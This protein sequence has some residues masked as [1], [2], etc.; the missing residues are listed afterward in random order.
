MA[1]KIGS[2]T[3]VHD[4]GHTGIDIEGHTATIGA[5]NALSGD[6]SGHVLNFNNTSQIIEVTAPDITYS[7]GKSNVILN[8]SNVDS[9]SKIQ[10]VYIKAIGNNSISGHGRDPSQI[11]SA[12]PTNFDGGQAH[13]FDISSNGLNWYV[14]RRDS[15]TIY[16]YTNTAAWDVTT[17]S[18]DQSLN[19]S[20]QFTHGGKDS[21]GQWEVKGIRISA[22][23]YKLFVN[24]RPVTYTTSKVHQYSLSTAYDLSTA[25]HDSSFYFKI[26]SVDYA[27]AAISYIGDSNNGVRDIID[28]HRS[29]TR[30]LVSNENNITAVLVLDS[31]WNLSGT[32]K[33]ESWGKFDDITD[34]GNAV[35]TRLDYD[36]HTVRN[37]KTGA[38]YGSYQ[39]F[40]WTEPWQLYETFDSSFTTITKETTNG[41]NLLN[42]ND[43]KFRPGGHHL[44]GLFNDSTG[45]KL[46]KYDTEDS[47]SA[48]VPASLGF[49]INVKWQGGYQPLFADS[50]SNLW[51]EFLSFDSGY[52]WYA[53][54]I[55][56]G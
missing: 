30:V 53:K 26:P 22:D 38:S 20:G 46:Y 23:G 4:E 44:V 54:E 16:S 48:I 10:H 1:F 40:R 37:F 32:K 29:G 55:Y 39:S 18:S 14:N 9:A 28:F 21:A 11:D 56:K 51:M 43:F 50:G 45:D 34:S 25:S 7:S 19:H 24:T 17:L 13:S 3:V 33:V 47:A 6:S 35:Q 15:N 41:V 31:A 5:S 27:D 12:T 8:F 36:Y 52:N 49:P 2:K 42:L